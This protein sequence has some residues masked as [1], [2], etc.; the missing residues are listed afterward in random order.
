[1]AGQQLVVT[2]SDGLANP[3]H[4]PLPEA[5]APGGNIATLWPEAI[6]NPLGSGPRPSLRS[7]PDQVGQTGLPA[8][9]A[10]DVVGLACGRLL[11]HAIC[12]L[13]AC[14]ARME[15]GVVCRGDGRLRSGV[16]G[17]LIRR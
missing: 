5:R 2:L 17:R 9:L 8:H 3:P 13:V 6:P 10:C 1:M 16:L 12:H 14:D 15:M 7:P 4:R 11:G